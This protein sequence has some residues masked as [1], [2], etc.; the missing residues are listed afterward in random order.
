[1]QGG[2]YSFTVL[3]AYGYQQ[4][5]RRLEQRVWRLEAYPAERKGGSG[6]TSAVGPA[7]WEEFLRSLPGRPR[8]VVIDRAAAIRQAVEAVW[9][10]IE[11]WYCEW[12][13]KQGVVRILHAAGYRDPAS[14]VHKALDRASSQPLI[15]R[16]SRRRRRR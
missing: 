16:T 4:G 3:G 1:M 5:A 9:P 15:G 6:V 7:A 10:G 2:E 12:H 8:R 14:P 11:I 13:L